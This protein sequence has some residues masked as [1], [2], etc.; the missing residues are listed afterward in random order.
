MVAFEQ[1]LLE[2]SDVRLDERHVHSVARQ[3]EAQRL[4]QSLDG[5]FCARV[6][7]QTRFWVTSLAGQTAHVD[8]ATCI[9]ILVQC[10]ISAIRGS[11]AYKFKIHLK[12]SH[13]YLNN[14]FRT[15]NVAI[16]W[17]A[18]AICKSFP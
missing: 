7:G 9:Y 2:E 12:Y 8:D 4:R 3:F 10:H 17:M 6:H 11:F 15:F 13:V 1:I 5:M 18:E 14:H 16:V